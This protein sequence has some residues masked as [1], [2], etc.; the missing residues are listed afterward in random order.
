MV[1]LQIFAIVAGLILFMMFMGCILPDKYYDILWSCLVF[2]FL[3]GGMLY[4]LYM[5]IFEPEVVYDVKDILRTM[6]KR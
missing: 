2:T 4:G 6:P 5:M 3:I 1:L